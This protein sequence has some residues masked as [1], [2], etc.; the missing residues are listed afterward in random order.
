MSKSL[1]YIDFAA[2]KAAVSLEQILRH[3][4]VLDKLKPHGA[5]LR[6]C[7]PIHNGDDPKQFSVTLEKNAWNCFSQCKHGGNMLEFVMQMEDC[8]LSEAAWKVNE[9][10]NLGLEA[11]AAVRFR[12]EPPTAKR[13]QTPEAADNTPRPPTPTAKPAPPPAT[14]QEPE[15][16][17]GENEPKDFFAL[18]NLDT[19]HPYLAE[20][21]L[22]AE[23]I[24]HFGIGYCPKGIMAGRIAIP[25]FNS[26]GQI[27]ANAGR[28]PGEPEEGKEKYRLPGKFKKTLEVFNI[29]RA[30]LEPDTSPLV[31]VEGFFGVMHLWQLGIR[32]VVALMGWS[33]SERQEAMIGKLVTPD[34]RIVL[35]L[36]NDEPGVAAQQKIAPRLAEHCFVRSFRWPEGVR[37]PDELTVEQVAALLR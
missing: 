32:R 7:C 3:Y 8:G 28:W 14:T 31:I 33:L 18:T 21:G 10:F 16:E 13:A 26:S 37:E 24:A 29:H 22:R 5:G 15:V 27:V 2:V 30:A 4:G 9:W 36:D 11:Q 20:R 25:I 1:G 35:M 23:T 6:G 34:S 19:T 12:K 17:T